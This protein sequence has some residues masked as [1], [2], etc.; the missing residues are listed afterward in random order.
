MSRTVGGSVRRNLD[1]M[2]ATGGES[3]HTGRAG[4]LATGA[5][6]MPH[7]EGM[8]MTTGMTLGTETTG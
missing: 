8:A 4:G 2:T 6:P 3:G 1:Y 5:G 7:A